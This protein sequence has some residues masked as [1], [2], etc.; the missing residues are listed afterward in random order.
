MSGY[1]SDSEL[2]WLFGYTS[3]ACYN[4]AATRT[5]ER[6]GPKLDLAMIQETTILPQDPYGVKY[7]TAPKIEL[8]EPQICGPQLDMQ[9]RVCQTRSVS[10]TYA[11]SRLWKALPCG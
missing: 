7:A 9:N 8:K 2:V 10:L 1:I 5:P 6:D 11:S 4:R 3:K